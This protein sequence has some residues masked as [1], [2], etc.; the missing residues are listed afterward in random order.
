MDDAWALECILASNGMD[1][2]G[3]G[4]MAFGAVVSISD[5]RYRAKILASSFGRQAEERTDNGVRQE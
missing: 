1:M 2:A 3:C 4:I 5:P